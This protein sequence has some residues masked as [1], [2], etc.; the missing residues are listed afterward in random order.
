MPKK[1]NDE[2]NGPEIVKMFRQSI[3]PYSKKLVALH[4]HLYG[5]LYRRASEIQALNKI[6]IHLQAASEDA[7]LQKYT[8]LPP[9]LDAIKDALQGHPPLSWWNL[10][11]TTMG[12]AFG[13]SND[14]EKNSQETQYLQ[15][16][17]EILTEMIRHFQSPNTKL[18]LEIRL[19]ALDVDARLVELDKIP[20]GIQEVNETLEYLTSEFQLLIKELKQVVSLPKESWSQNNQ[21]FLLYTEKANRL[22]GIAKNVKETD[23]GTF[24]KFSKQEDTEKLKNS[25]RNFLRQFTLEDTSE[26]LDFWQMQQLNCLF[27]L[28][29]YF[30]DLLLELPPKELYSFL[31][32][33]DRLFIADP[34]LDK[35][36]PAIFFSETLQNY[37]NHY[38][39]EGKRRFKDL[40]TRTKD[41]KSNAGAPK[42]LVTPY[43]EYF[44]S[45]NDL[46]QI[47][48]LIHFKDKKTFTSKCDPAQIQKDILNRLITLTNLSQPNDLDVLLKSFS[49]EEKEER[50]FLIQEIIL[51]QFIRWRKLGIY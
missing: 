14:E 7:K 10:F 43:K 30:P 21:T 47:C 42:N 11:T 29:T 37:A 28:F 13:G 41:A 9:I 45:E 39:E 22:M 34:N 44:I 24:I 12:Y 51:E 35:K 25:I 38:A 33:A 49:E 6:L 40:C 18:L 17:S 8:H 48:S 16:I 46:H 20:T 36:R 5:S 1:M 15:A 50:Y 19:T 2:A 31:R 23:L 4:P 26:T 32:Q 3:A 27:E